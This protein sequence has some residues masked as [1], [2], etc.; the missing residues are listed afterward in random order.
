[1]R[2]TLYVPLG[3]LLLIAACASTSKPAPTTDPTS[4]A[5]AVVQPAPAPQSAPS[6]PAPQP[7]PVVAA[8]T[9]APAPAPLT[10]AAATKARAFLDQLE[11]GNGLEPEKISAARASLTSAEKLSGRPRQQA[12]RTLATQLGTDA[13][14]AADP[15]KVRMLSTAVTELVNMR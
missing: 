7:Q 4:S 13:G 2:S 5:S 3:L 14:R 11:R 6:T 15:P 12:L 8:A 9:P 1:M 10:P